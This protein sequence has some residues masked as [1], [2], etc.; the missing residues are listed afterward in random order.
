M[1]WSCRTHR[2]RPQGRGSPGFLVAR[3][4]LTADRNDARPNAFH[5]DIS[6]LRTEPFEDNPASLAMALVAGLGQLHAF[7]ALDQRR[8]KRPVFRHMAQ[9]Q[10]PTLAIAVLERIERGHFLPLVVEHRTLWPLG[11]EEG[12]RRRDQ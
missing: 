9:E 7:R 4:D 5:D 10:L 1:C 8:G 11:I 3:R 12:P 2:H 6:T